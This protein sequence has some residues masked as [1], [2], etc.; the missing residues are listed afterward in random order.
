MRKIPHNIPCP[1]FLWICLVLFLFAGCA[2]G[3]QAP[4][5]HV[6]RGIT[7]L[8]LGMTPEQV[9]QFFTIKEDIDPFSALLTKYSK[10]EKGEAVSRQNKALQKQFFLISSGVG[11]LPDGI[12]S[13]DVRTHYNVVYQIGFHYDESSVKKLGWQGVTYPYLTKYG[14]P[15]KDTGSGY[16]WDDGRSRLDI[17][18]SGSIINVFFTDQMLETE[19]KKSERE[20][21]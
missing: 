15:T 20:K 9:G 21:P 5:V 2:S 11:K 19:V 16:V 12:T 1:L 4:A 18:S 10:Q 8:E 7:G 3:H 13:A 17:E 14:K 6:P